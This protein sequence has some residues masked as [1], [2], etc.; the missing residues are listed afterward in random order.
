MPGTDYDRFLREPPRAHDQNPDPDVFEMVLTAAPIDVE[1]AA[2][3]TTAAWAFNGSVPGPTIDA[4]LGDTL[5]VHFVN[6]LPEATSI[7]W[8]GIATPSTMDGSQLSQVA[9]PRSGYHRYEFQLNV[10]GT[11]WYHPHRNTNEQIERGLHGV[12]VVRDPKHDAALG[13][14]PEDD[15]VLVLDDV[16]LDDD[17]QLSLFATDLGAD[18]VPWERAEDLANSRVGNHVLQNGRIVDD[19]RPPLLPVRAG[20]PY[21]LRLVNAAS[22]RIFRF[23]LHE[24]G[25]SCL[26]AVGSDQGLWNAAEE[27][28]PIDKVRNT[29][30]H[31]DELISNPDTTRGITLTPGDRMELVLVPDGAVDD[32]FV[33]RSHDY[34]KGKHTAYRDPAGDLLFG[35]DHF[36]GA[37]PPEDYLAFQITEA[38]GDRPTWSPPAAL[39][40]DPI[41]AL[42]PAD[43]LPTLPVFLGHSPPNRDTGMV[44]FFVQVDR[45]DALLEAVHAREHVLPIDYAPR[46]MMRQRAQHGW[47]VQLGS[48]RIWEVVNFTGN[49]HNFHVHGFRFQHLST[50]YI[51]LDE[52]EFN[53]TEAPRRVAWEDTLRIARR[54][55]LTLGRSYTI[56]RLATR[57]DDDDLP[58][59]LRRDATEILAGGLDPT[60]SRSGGWVVHCHFLEHSA[61]GMMSFVTVTR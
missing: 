61:M 33:L 50:E 53:K 52:P 19:A 49:D 28:R 7:H 9:V 25:A 46:P 3:K 40:H 21:R 60:P 39:R 48:E 34:Q 17:F 36:D 57:F 54:P 26:F 15:H 16:K 41:E 2:G 22:G 32:R 56:T 14:A 13:I 44:M 29:L 5:I 59:R 4:K 30:G 58:F 8:H 42:R 51:D 1:Y 45:A 47:H 20:R 38:R 43:D 24:A 23:D 18:F 35:H 12:L 55:G 11:F 37:E 6:L 31:H 27:V 10:A